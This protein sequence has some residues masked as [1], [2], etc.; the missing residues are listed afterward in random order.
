MSATLSSPNY[1]S[2]NHGASRGGGGQAAASTNR[3]VK[4]RFCTHEGIK[5]FT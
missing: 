5:R 2:R 4:N 3:S 1:I